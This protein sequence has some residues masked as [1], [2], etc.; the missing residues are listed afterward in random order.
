MQ[1]QKIATSN[2]PTLKA[3]TLKSGTSL[4]QK[5]HYS[6]KILLLLFHNC[7]PKCAICR[8]TNFKLRYQNENK[9]Y[10]LAEKFHYFLQT[11]N[12]RKKKHHEDCALLVEPIVALSVYRF[13]TKFFLVLPQRLF[14]M[15]VKLEIL[16]R[17]T[18]SALGK[19]NY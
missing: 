19:K 9:C 1:Y 17:E 13:Y 4:V 12:A 10:I 6:N 2:K 18:V 5:K 14:C 8:K 11:K 3:T 7:S 16:S 15:Q